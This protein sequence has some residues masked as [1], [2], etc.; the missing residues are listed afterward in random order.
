MP[1]QLQSLVCARCGSSERHNVRPG[2]PSGACKN[3][4]RLRQQARS[5]SAEGSA[6][7][8]AYYQKTRDIQI[9]RSRQSAKA[10]PAR[11]AAYSRADYARNAEKRRAAARRRYTAN[12]AAYV[13]K[14]TLRKRHVKL[15]TPAWA[16]I[17]AITMVY[18]EA[19]R[20]SAET[21]IVH[22]VD[23]VIPLRGRLC[24]GLHVHQNLQILVAQDNLRKSNC[25]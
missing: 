12:K 5:R 9:E 19:R 24:S 22:H 6:Y 25:H 3:C 18:N 21:G 14:A 4:H 23:H 16:D 8:E 7:R 10:D 20:L 17:S 1:K 13:E 2:R 11:H 15:R